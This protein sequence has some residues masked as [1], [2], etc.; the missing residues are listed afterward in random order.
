MTSGRLKN[1]NIVAQKQHL[2]ANIVIK[3][4]VFLAGM[5]RVGHNLIKPSAV[6]GQKKQWGTFH[7]SIDGLTS[8]PQS[9]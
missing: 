1:N 9:F 4:V 3:R 8:D 6:D 2:D 5:L 7:R